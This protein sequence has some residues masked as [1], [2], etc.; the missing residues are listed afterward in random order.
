MT[1]APVT[2]YF[3]EGMRRRVPKIENPPRATIG[4]GDLLA[5]V[6]GHD[7]R[8]EATLRRDE[9]TRVAAAAEKLDGLT[10]ELAT[11]HRALLHSFAPARGQFTRRQSAEGFGI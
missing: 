6:A 8:F 1:E 4:S 5:L 11:G 9:F 10:E 7:C 3:F 2:R